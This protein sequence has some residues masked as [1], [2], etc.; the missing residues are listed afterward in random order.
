MSVQNIDYLDTELHLGLRSC[1]Y[2]ETSTDYRKSIGFLT[3]ARTKFWVKRNEE[4][5]G[6]VYI[7]PW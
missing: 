3:G 4:M 7:C 1:D 6:S 2:S 5:K